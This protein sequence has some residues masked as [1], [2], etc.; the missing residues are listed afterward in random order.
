MVNCKILQLW[1]KLVWFVRKAL[2]TKMS[3][4][5]LPWCSIIMSFLA[6][7]VAVVYYDI[8]SSKGFKGN[9]HQKVQT[10]QTN[11]WTEY[12]LAWP[13]KTSFRLQQGEC[14][15]LHLLHTCMP[16]RVLIHSLHA[17]IRGASYPPY[18][19]VVLTGSVTGRAL[20]DSG[21]LVLSQQIYSYLQFYWE[22]V[23]R[24]RTSVDSYV[25]RAM[26]NSVVLSV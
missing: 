16:W 3:G 18:P 12:L 14:A 4:S 13:D 26:P 19:G 9:A 2:L 24:Y 21:L 25:H 23:F 6:V 17:T 15:G 8:Y 5:R 10:W 11:L 22:M 20:T 1:L 7:V